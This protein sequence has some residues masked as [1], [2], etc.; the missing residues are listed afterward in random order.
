MRARQFWVGAGCASL[1]VAAVAATAWFAPIDLRHGA[2]PAAGGVPLHAFGG[3]SL[4]SGKTAGRL[5]SALANLADHAAGLDPAKAVA[6]LH[7]LNPAA[8]FRQNSAGATPEVLIDAATRGSAQQLKTALVSLGLEHASVFANA[9]GGWLP[10]TA[11]AAAAARPEVA[12][13][14][15]SLPHKHAAVALQ[16]DYVQHSYALRQSNPTLTGAGVTVG[17]LSDS[18]D[19]YAV[20]AE[21]GSGVPAAGLNGYASNGFTA[22][23]EDDE[24]DGA[25]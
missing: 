23:A 1:T 10:V 12:Y 6:Q 4:K 14:H 21:P 7:S 9:V 25:L 18:F 3:H 13:L 17:V 2:A 8:R 15:A 20:Y 19:C 11:I 22:T 5:D 24:A 16:G